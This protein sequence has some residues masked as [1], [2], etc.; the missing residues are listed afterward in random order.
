MI[1]LT[2]LEDMNAMF[3]AFF[4]G[5]GSWLGI[6]LLLSICIGLLS[7]WKYSGVLTLPV[8]LFLGIDYVGKDLLWHALIMWFTDVFILLY[9]VKELKDR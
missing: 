6:L 5:N 7:K 2:V 1:F 8:M 3:E 9:L 4:Y